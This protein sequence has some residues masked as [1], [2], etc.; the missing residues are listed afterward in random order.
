MVSWDSDGS[1]DSDDS[2]DNDK[3]SI[4]KALASI[5]INNK[6]SIFDMSS[7]CLMAKPTKVKYDESDDDE[8]E[9]DSCRE[10]KNDDDDD[11]EYTKEE[12]LDMCEQV[13]ACN[14]MKRKECKELRKKLKSLEQS[15]D[16]LNATHERLMEAHEKLGKT[17]SNLEK[18][19]S[20]LMEQ[21]K[22]EEAKKKQVIVTYDV[23]LTCDLTNTS[24]STTTSNSPLSDGLT[25]DASL[26]VENETL[27]EKVNELT[28]ALGNAD[29]GDA[30]LLKCLGSQRFSLNKEGLGYTPKKG[31]AAFVT[32]KVSFVKGN[33]RFCNRCKQVGHIEQYCKINKNK[34]PNVSSIKFDS[35][36]MLFKGANGVKA[37]FIGTPIVG[38]KKKAIW[39]PKTLVTNLQGP[40]QVWVPKRIDLLL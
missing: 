9:S 34:L 32:P 12:I 2:S 26:M 15:F 16:E 25:C 8:Y 6:P 36:Y 5:A 30:R 31:K 3:K 10:D 33:G 20:S 40:K 18:A 38:P 23:G 22:K 28:R 7:I 11:E 4:K 24:Y 1:S 27:K 37:K 21:V 13:H 39:V 29:G 17:H 19:H 35:C 14:E